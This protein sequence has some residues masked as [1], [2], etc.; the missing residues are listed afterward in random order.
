MLSHVDRQAVVVTGV[1]LVVMSSSIRPLFR[2]SIA[3]SFRMQWLTAARMLRAPCSAG[4]SPRRE[5]ARRFGDVVDQQH[6]A[7]VDFTDDVDRLDLG[8]AFAFLA[9]TRAR[10]A[11]TSA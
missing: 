11:S 7:A 2:R 3:V 6:I 10:Q 8:G 5:R 1:E 9:P 4:F